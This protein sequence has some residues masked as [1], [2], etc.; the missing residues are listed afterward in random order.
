MS[1]G[2]PC[3]CFLRRLLLRIRLDLLLVSFAVRSQAIFE[4]GLCVENAVELLVWAHTG[5]STSYLETTHSVY[6]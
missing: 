6:L 4:R 5:T 2:V 1:H 3:R